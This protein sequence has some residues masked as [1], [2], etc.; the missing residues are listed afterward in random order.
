MSY[1][2][3]MS[4]STTNIKFS[5]TQVGKSVTQTFKIANSKGVD[6]L[7]VSSISLSK[8]DAFSIDVTNCIIQPGEVRSVEVTFTPSV[9]GNYKNRV[10]IRSDAEDNPIW[11]IQL[12][13]SGT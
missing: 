6:A 3:S 9:S 11:V 5:P 13:G 4:A 7:T 2:A 8:G 1:D 12:A 10:I